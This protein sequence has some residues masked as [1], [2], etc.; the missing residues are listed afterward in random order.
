MLF[1]SGTLCSA[2]PSALPEAS[3]V[4]SI[5]PPSL[6]LLPV[7]FCSQQQ[8]ICRTLAK[9]LSSC[10]SFTQLADLF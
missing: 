1:A 3:C 10:Q 4:D 7:G 8:G 2:M 9:L 6:R 5:S